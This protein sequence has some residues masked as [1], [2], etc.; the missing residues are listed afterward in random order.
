MD[1]QSVPVQANQS[2]R[3]LCSYAIKSK[4]FHWKSLGS[5]NMSSIAVSAVQMGVNFPQF[6]GT[7][8]L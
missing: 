6:S 8:S 3:S 1:R 2:G 4:L 5:V 7:V